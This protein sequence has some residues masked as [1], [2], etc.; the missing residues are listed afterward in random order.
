M[1]FIL[2]FEIGSHYV[3]QAGL[4]LIA[5]CLSLWTV[6]AINM[7]HLPSWNCKLFF[8]LGKFV[9][10]FYLFTFYYSFI[11]MCIHCL[12]HFS[13]TPP[14]P[15]FPPQ[16]QAGP[17]LLLSLVLLKKRDKH[18]EEDKVFLL[19]KDSYTEI[20]LALLSCTRV[21]T[22]VDSSLTDLYPGYWNF[23]LLRGKSLPFFSS[24]GISHYVLNA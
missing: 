10:L 7:Y 2:F 22:H 11:H 20:F 21:M 19:V 15:P 5:S 12:G 3:D 16:F 23:K 4:N 8:F 24:F 14:S 18:N 9:I 6:G 1:Q 13:P 17:V